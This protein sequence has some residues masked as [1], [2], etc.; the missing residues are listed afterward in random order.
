LE[1]STTL[2]TVPN[3][4]G[5]S[6]NSFITAS[7]GIAT[8]KRTAQQILM[9]AG[10]RVGVITRTVQTIPIII[11]SNVGVPQTVGDLSST[12]SAF[13]ANGIVGAQSPPA[14]SMAPTGALVDLIE[15]VYV[16]VPTV[17]PSKP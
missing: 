3:V 5:I 10:F 1:L 2:I 12:T 15:I 17:G 7:S 13:G 9:S 4:V 11:S 6:T 14:G 8:G 16:Y